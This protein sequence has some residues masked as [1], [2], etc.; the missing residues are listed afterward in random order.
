MVDQRDAESRVL[1]HI[2]NLKELSGDPADVRD[3]DIW[4]TAAGALKVRL[5][6]VTKTVT[7]S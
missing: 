5:D 7:V 2:V 4:V 3:G 6:G 1:F